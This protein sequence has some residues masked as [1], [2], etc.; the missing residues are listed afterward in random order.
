MVV[1]TSPHMSDL[2]LSPEGRTVVLGQTVVVAD[3]CLQDLLMFRLQPGLPT[4]LRVPARP[5]LVL[6]LLAVVLHVLPQAAWVRVLL[7]AAEHLTLVGFLTRKMLSL[8][9]LLEELCR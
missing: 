4:E 7:L 5:Q 8:A 1:V 2:L 3:R 6:L 9:I